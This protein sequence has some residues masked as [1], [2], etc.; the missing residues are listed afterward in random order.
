MFFHNILAQLVKFLITGKNSL[1]ACDN[2][3]FR[4]LKL[5]ARPARG[6]KP[7]S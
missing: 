4:D 2:Y 5:S 3:T 7:T 1:P 6:W